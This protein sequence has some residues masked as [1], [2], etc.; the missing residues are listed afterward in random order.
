MTLSG[1]MAVILR[2]YNECVRFESL[3]YV[4][5]VVARPILTAIGM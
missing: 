1:V 3:L 4:K 2:Y 5:L